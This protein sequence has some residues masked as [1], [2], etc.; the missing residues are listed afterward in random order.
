MTSSREHPELLINQDFAKLVKTIEEEPDKISFRLSI[1]NA[2]NDCDLLTTKHIVF[3][4]ELLKKYGLIE[5]DS[6]NR[7]S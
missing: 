1:S 6:Y 3:L 5:K 2:D 7:I 4:S